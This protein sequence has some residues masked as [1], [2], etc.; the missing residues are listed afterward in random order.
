MENSEKYAKVQEKVEKFFTRKH[1]KLWDR[2]DK[3]FNLNRII[4]PQGDLKYL[5]YFTQI[6]IKREL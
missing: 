3:S 2:M 5:T 1:S 6:L 4:I